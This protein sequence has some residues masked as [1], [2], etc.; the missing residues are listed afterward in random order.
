[1]ENEVRGEVELEEI[2]K[3]RRKMLD[4]DVGMFEVLN[5]DTLQ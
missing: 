2:E 4:V 5:G 1:L 3:K